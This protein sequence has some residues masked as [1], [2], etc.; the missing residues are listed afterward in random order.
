MR[1]FREL[2]RNHRVLLSLILNDLRTRYLTNYLGILWVFI[3]PVATTLILYFVF[4]FGFKAPAHT[5]FPFVLWLVC[6]LV[7]WFFIVESLNSGCASVKEYSFLV[8]KIV[9]EVSLLPLVKLGSALVVHMFFISILVVLLLVYGYKPTVY[10][11]Q[12]VYYVCCL[13]ALLLAFA[14]VTSS[15][16]VF[17]PDLA[18][19]VSMAAQFGFWLTPVFW[20]IDAM[21]SPL[22]EYLRLSPFAY[23][24]EGFRDTFIREIWFWDRLKQ[25]MFF[26]GIVIVLMFAGRRIFKKLRPHFADVL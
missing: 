23:V 17:F 2:A 8:K 4:Q 7:P 15:M 12:I 22:S 5:S 10:W 14:W 16:V 25:T 6:G 13:F 3:Q 18:Q 9:F 21:G 26:W 24:V 1:I 20:D 11:F 19:L